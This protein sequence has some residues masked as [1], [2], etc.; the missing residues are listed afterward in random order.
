MGWRGGGTAV[1]GAPEAGTSGAG[2]DD[3]GGED[4]VA[5]TTVVGDEG[6]AMGGS[7][8]TAAASGAGTDG[9]TGTARAGTQVQRR[10]WRTPVLTGSTSASHGGHGCSGD[11]GGEVTCSKGKEVSSK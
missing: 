3:A 9:A 1:V 8:D 7:G 2:G 6:V 10:G 4:D 5:P 11:A